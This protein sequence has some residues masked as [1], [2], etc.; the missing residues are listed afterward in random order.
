M[1][2]P[3]PYTS[4]L[5]NYNGD[6]PSH[7]SVNRVPQDTAWQAAF[8]RDRPHCYPTLVAYRGYVPWKA[9]Q[10]H[11]YLAEDGWRDTETDAAW[12]LAVLAEDVRVSGEKLDA[13]LSEL[14]SSVHAT[15]EQSKEIA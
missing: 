13:T 6:E 10:R 7:P 15:T 3:S 4:Y 9:E 11:Y 8:L 1:T 5:G 14:H 2:R 12:V